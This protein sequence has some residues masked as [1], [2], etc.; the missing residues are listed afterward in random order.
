MKSLVNWPSNENHKLPEY[1]G[2]EKD[3]FKVI[4]DYFTN[5]SSPLSTFTLYNVLVEA[6]VRSEAAD[7]VFRKSKE[8]VSE[9]DGNLS[10]DSHDS[11][12]SLVLK[13]S[14]PISRFTSTPFALQ[15][16]GKQQQLRYVQN[17]F[18]SSFYVSCL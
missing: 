2:S 12:Q 4:C 5:S 18:E 8:K 10:V 17:S 7:L 16:H 1:Q 11:V 15:H 13:M 9:D 14:S 6:F 3:V